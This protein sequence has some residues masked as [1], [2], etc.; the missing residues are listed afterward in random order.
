MSIVNERRGGARFVSLANI[1]GLGKRMVSSADEI[2]VSGLREEFDYSRV[3]R[4][5]KTEIEKSGKWLLDGLTKGKTSVLS[6]TESILRDKYRQL[7]QKLN[8]IAANMGEQYDV[9]F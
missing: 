1:L 7:E 6:D 2:T 4:I 9:F 3:E 5:L 8:E